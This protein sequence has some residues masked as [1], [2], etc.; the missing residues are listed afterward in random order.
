MKVKDR[1][2]KGAANADR[3]TSP[4]IK[5]GIDESW[6]NGIPFESSFGRPTRK[7]SPQQGRKE[8]AEPIN[9]CRAS[10]PIYTTMDTE[11]SPASETRAST[12]TCSRG[13]INNTK[14]CS[15]K[16]PKERAG[17]SNDG[18]VHSTVYRTP[19]RYHRPYCLSKSAAS[20]RKTIAGSNIPELRLDRADSRRMMAVESAPATP[21]GRI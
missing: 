8:N 16:E 5:S 3:D 1:R 11:L 17:L 19:T 4:T 10:V 13:S 12:A 7:I 21:L 15:G 9:R 6:Q 20:Y 18:E 14:D 2:P